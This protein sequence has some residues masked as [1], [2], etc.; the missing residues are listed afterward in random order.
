MWLAIGIAIAGYCIGDGLKNFKNPNAQSLLDSLDDDD[1]H[2]LLSEKDVHYF[3]GISKEDAKSL[4]RD[5]EDIP[6][7][8]INGNK[9]FPKAKLQK[10]LK[11]IGS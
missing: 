2:E 11:D 1:S 10:W 3:I 5:H 7:I 6:H 9:Y 8:I 4:V